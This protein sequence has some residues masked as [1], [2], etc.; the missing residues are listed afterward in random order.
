MSRLEQNERLH[1]APKGAIERD[2]GQLGRAGKRGEAGIC[3]GLRRCALPSGERN[4]VVNPGIVDPK[5]AGVLGLHERKLNGPECLMA[6]STKPPEL[7][8]RDDESEP[9]PAARLDRALERLAG[10]RRVAPQEVPV[11]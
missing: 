11:A 8:L 5:R 3:P 7:H 10:L 4:D 9:G 6:T 2:E 1:F